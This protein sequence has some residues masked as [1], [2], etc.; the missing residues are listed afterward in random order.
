MNQKKELSWRT[1]FYCCL[2]IGFFMPSCAENI[3]DVCE[4]NNQISMNEK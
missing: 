1:I 2:G 3:V 4:H